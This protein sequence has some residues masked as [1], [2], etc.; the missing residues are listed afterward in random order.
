M[1][2]ANVK[3]FLALV[4]ASPGKYL[5]IVG[6]RCD[7]HLIAEWFNSLSGLQVTHVPYKGSAPAHT[8]M[9]GQIAYAIETA[10]ATMPHVK[11]GRLKA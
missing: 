4:R 8:V 6:H 1:P 3:E 10:A 2:A 5:R 9:G 11:S 7:R